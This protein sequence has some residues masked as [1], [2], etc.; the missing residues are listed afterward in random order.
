MIFQPILAHK[1]GF[2]GA[3]T[4]ILSLEK[5]IECMDCRHPAEIGSF[6]QFEQFVQLQQ[7]LDGREPVHIDGA[8]FLFDQLGFGV[9]RFE[10][11]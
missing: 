1:K 9:A 5:P 2:S 3:K 6:G 10:Y 8:Q 11:L 7:G 4:T